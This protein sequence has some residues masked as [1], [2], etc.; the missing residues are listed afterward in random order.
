MPQMCWVLDSTREFA[1]G[2]PLGEESCHT[3]ISVMSNVWMS[4]VTHML[5]L[6]FQSCGSRVLKLHTEL[7]KKKTDFIA[8][9]VL[10]GNKS[11][12][13][14][15]WVM[16]QISIGKWSMPHV[17]MSHG[18]LM[19]ETRHTYAGPWILLANWQV[20][21]CRKIRHFTNIRELCYSY[22]WV[23]IYIYIYIHIHTHIRQ[24]RHFTN[25]RELCYSYE[26]VKPWMGLHHRCDV[27]VYVYVCIC[28]CI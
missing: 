18:T 1:G 19:N 23:Y 4:Q 16:S 3:Y 12:H 9:G 14:Y 22:E 2:V 10:Q 8:G 11:Y 27:C 7:G 5:G 13:S 20:G 24:I 25:I 21:F 26:W 6:A 17:Q 28:I 15:T